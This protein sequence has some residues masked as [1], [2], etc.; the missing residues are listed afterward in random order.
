MHGSM[1]GYILLVSACLLLRR[2]WLL[3]DRG[4]AAQVP[5]LTLPGRSR[6]ATL[7]TG[8]RQQDGLQCPPEPDF[9]IGVYTPVVSPAA[10]IFFREEPTVP[11]CTCASAQGGYSRSSGFPLTG[12]C[13]PKT[14]RSWR[15]LLTC[16]GIKHLLMEK[17]LY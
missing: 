1:A 16:L 12:S 5:P 3:L 17:K 8:C 10:L 9:V 11:S 13:I 4:V 2:L 14:L 7:V 6:R 15:P